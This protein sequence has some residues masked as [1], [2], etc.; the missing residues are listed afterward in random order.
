MLCALVFCACRRTLGIKHS[1]GHQYGSR[2]PDLQAEALAIFSTC[3]RWYI[4]IE[5]EWIPREQNGQADYI[6]RLVD[7][8]DWMLNSE[9]FSMLDAMWG[10]HTIDRLANVFNHQLP[11]FNSRFWDPGT[12]VDTFTCDWAGENNW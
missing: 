6:S 5:P 7:Y 3:L 8:D 2:K 11:L 9:I 1:G 10:P 12:A 4:R